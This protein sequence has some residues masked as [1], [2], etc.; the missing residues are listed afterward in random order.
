MLAD[1]IGK[2]RGEMSGNTDLYKVYRLAE[3]DTYTYKLIYTSPFGY[4]ESEIVYNRFVRSVEYRNKLGMLQRSD[5]TVINLAASSNINIVFAT[6]E[7][8]FPLVDVNTLLVAYYRE[9]DG[10]K[11]Y[12]LIF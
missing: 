6:V 11:S 12:R 5:E 2:L 3:T 1:L 9:R 8:Y 10:I 7:E 4:T